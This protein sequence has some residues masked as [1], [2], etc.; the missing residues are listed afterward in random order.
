M[1]FTQSF[2]WRRQWTLN[3]SYRL[4]YNASVLR[5]KCRNKLCAFCK[6]SGDSEMWSNS[7]IASTRRIK[8]WKYSSGKIFHRHWM[9]FKK[10]KLPKFRSLP[11]RKI[12]HN[13][14]WCSW[15]AV[16]WCTC[17]IKQAPLN[18]IQSFAYISFF[19]YTWLVK[20]QCHK[21]FGDP[22]KN[23]VHVVNWNTFN[24]DLWASHACCSVFS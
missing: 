5:Q 24:C 17:N 3:A 6:H 18:F 7:Q 8:C 19:C 21:H 1:F 10:Q 4:P 14:S 11:M 16:R 23:I 20:P 9:S 13:A 22:R 12:L 2:R 15:D